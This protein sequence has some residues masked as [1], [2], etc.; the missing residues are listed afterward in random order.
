MTVRCTGSAGAPPPDRVSRACQSVLWVWPQEGEGF[1]TSPCPRLLVDRVNL[2]RPPCS[3]WRS[4]GN[5]LTCSPTQ[6]HCL[7]ALGSLDLF[8]LLLLS[9]SLQ[10][11]HPGPPLRALSVTVS[12]AGEWATWVGHAGGGWPTFGSRPARGGIPESES[13]ADQAEMRPLTRQF[14]T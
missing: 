11:P 1:H 13:T 7:C 6:G 8:T 14:L 5:S 2:A 9:V 10:L 3:S 12:L 4:P